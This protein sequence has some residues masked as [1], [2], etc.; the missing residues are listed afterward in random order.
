MQ[1]NVSNT[2]GPAEEGE[3]EEMLEDPQDELEPFVDWIHRV[4]HSVEERVK[5]LKMRS[6]I[7]EARIRKWKWARNLYT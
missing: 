7:E 4:T 3:E 6:W 2:A 5:S 1:S